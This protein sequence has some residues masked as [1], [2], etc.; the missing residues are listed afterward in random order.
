MG[1]SRYKFIQEEGTYFVTL[2]VQN[3]IPIFTRPAT[4]QIL[5]DSLL[6]LQD[7]GLTVFEYVILE[8][9][10]HLT[11]ESEQVAKD[12]ARFKSYTARSI[13]DYLS[14]NKVSRILNQ[15]ETLKLQHKAD[16]THQFLQEGVH[17]EIIHNDPMMRQKIEYIHNNPVKRGYV[18]EATHWRYSSARNYLGK[19]GLFEVT[20]SW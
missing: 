16:R 13:I 3:W 8:N 10:I 1:R 2:T 19:V 15:L 9:H 17:P 12:I 14:E 20:R 4:V 5:F 7:E 11:V 18:D 6:F